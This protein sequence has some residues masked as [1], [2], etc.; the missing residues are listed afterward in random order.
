MVTIEQG[1][2]ELLGLS[3]SELANRVDELS[4]ADIQRFSLTLSS[5]ACESAFLDAYLEERGA[6]GCGDNGDLSGRKAG[7][8]RRKRVRKAMGYT[9]P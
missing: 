9:Y 5:L 1:A 8:K 7:D 3:P 4:M 2:Y 6:A